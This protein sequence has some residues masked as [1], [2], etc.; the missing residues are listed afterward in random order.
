M[1]QKLARLNMTRILSDI[2]AELLAENIAVNSVAPSTAISTPGSDRY[3]PADYPTERVE[4]LAETAL[5]LCH[6]P[7]QERTGLV[8]YSLHFPLAHNLPV[9]SLDG[10]EPLTPPEIPA[11][12]SGLISST[13]E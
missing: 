5:A 9:Y 10:R 2:Q 11:Y 4:Y 1:T 12:A 13:G 7:A 6:R 3:I 8:T